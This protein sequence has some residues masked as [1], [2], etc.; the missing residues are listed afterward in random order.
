MGHINVLTSGLGPAGCIVV[1]GT[2]CGKGRRKIG[3]LRLARLQVGTG[4]VKKKGTG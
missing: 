2:V 4:V 3:R 1:S